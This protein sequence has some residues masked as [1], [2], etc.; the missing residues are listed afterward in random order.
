MVA[1]AG[2]GREH[3]QRRLLERDR[4]D[5]GALGQLLARPQEERDAGPAPV[6]DEAL[7][8][9]EGLGVGLARDPGDVLV[10]VELTAHDVLGQD[11]QHRAEDLVLLL[12]DGPRLQRR[13]RL[14]RGEG[15]HL[16]QVGDDHV[17]VGAGRLVEVGAGL[18]PEGLRDVDLDVVDVVAV[19]DRLEQPV[20][21]AE[22][23]DVLRRLLAEEVVDPEDLVLVEHL[24]QAG[25]QAAGASE[26]GAE[27]LLHDDPAAL[28]QPRLGELGHDGERRLGRDAQVVQPARALPQLGLGLLDRLA[29]RDGA[30]AARHPLGALGQVAQVLL[31]DVVA[32]VAGG[33]RW[34]RARGTPRGPSP[35]AR[36]RRRG[37][38]PSARSAAGA[39]A[40]AGACAWTGP[41]WRRRARRSWR[42]SWRQPAPARP[43]CHHESDREV[44]AVVT[45]GTGWGVL[46]AAKDPPCTRQSL[47]TLAAFR[48]WGSSAG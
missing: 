45:P 22:R 43:S 30:R 37:G 4:D 44:G 13:R 21:E 23:E 38:R 41:P 40:P 47:P 42:R 35:P 7:Q 12:A 1:H 18:E 26:V 5:A 24:V 36:W 34:R 32:A 48:P 10:A 28:D 8:R 6:V 17:A 31:A 25:V 14:H 33:S 20:G 15:Q 2:A 3:R 46:Q 11:R 9:D 27:R 16:E 29:Q 39:S 19:P